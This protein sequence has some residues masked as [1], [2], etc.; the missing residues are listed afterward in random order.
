MYTFRYMYNPEKNQDVVLHVVA[1]DGATTPYHSRRIKDEYPAWKADSFYQWSQYGQKKRKRMKERFFEEEE[2]ETMKYIINKFDENVPVSLDTCTVSSCSPCVSSSNYVWTI[3]TV[4]GNIVAMNG[5]ELKQEEQEP[6]MATLNATTDLVAQQK[7]YALTR[8]DNLKYFKRN[9]LK[10]AFGLKDD[11]YPNN[12]KEL[13]ERFATGRYVI[14]G[15]DEDNFWGLGESIRFRD[16]AK[17][18]DYE[19]YAKANEKMEAAFTAA[20]DTIILTDADPIKVISDFESA[21]FH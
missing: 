21:T 13:R 12:I 8:L 20:R 19:G 2:R 10:A 15:K 9:P 18:E 6:T 16:P 14:D 4:P 5:V 3:N 7:N 11:D 1:P 17:K